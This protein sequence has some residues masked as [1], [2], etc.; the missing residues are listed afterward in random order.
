[1]SALRK[2]SIFF[3]IIFLGSV[4]SAD[5]SAIYSIIGSITPVDK[6]TSI[7]LFSATKGELSKNPPLVEMRYKEFPIGF[8]KTTGKISADNLPPDRYK[9]IIET[10][11]GKIEGID[12]FFEETGMPPLATGEFSE[13]KRQEIQDIIDHYKL[14]EEKRKTL[15]ITGAW[16]KGLD[17]R[18]GVVYIILLMER[19]S[20]LPTPEPVVTYRVEKWL[21]RWSGDWYRKKNEYLLLH[22]D[23]PP[24]RIFKGLTWI[25]EPALGNINLTPENPSAQINYTIPEK[26]PSA[27]GFVPPHDDFFKQG[28]GEM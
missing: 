5:E 20:T 1:M 12:Q 25:F 9:I 16:G 7:K 8:D 27:K 26:F 17:E 18:K 4:I 15:Y 13:K 21:Y 24:V 19:Q 3:A 22:R 10:A 2:L 23:M 28:F 14:H 11:Q 6:I